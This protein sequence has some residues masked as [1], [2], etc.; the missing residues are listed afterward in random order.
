MRGTFR[1]A[2]PFTD[3]RALVQTEDGA[4]LAIDTAGQTLYTLAAGVT[5]S[6]MTIYGGDTVVLSGGTNQALYSLSQGKMLTEFL[7]NTIS[8]FHEDGA[9]MVRQ[10]NRWGLMD[11]TG[12]LLTAP[13]YYYLSTWARGCTPP[14]ARTARPPQWTRT[15]TSPT[16]RPALSAASTSCATA[17]P[18]TAQ[19]AAA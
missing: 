11:V 10:V 7:Y 3:G 12:R 4:Y 19:P 8:E 16:A 2:G 15:A 9:A 17:C 18:G 1:N 6:Y 13:T 14:A 5:P